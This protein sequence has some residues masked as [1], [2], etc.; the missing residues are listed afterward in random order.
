MAR[1]GARGLPGGT[2]QALLASREAR[3]QARLGRRGRCEN[4]LE[5]ARSAFAGRR[6]DDDPDWVYWVSSAVLAADAGRAHLD[7]GLPREA[8]ADLSTGL[9][10][11]GSAQ[12]RNRALHLTSLAQ[13]HLLAGEVEEAATATDAALALAR[14]N[15]SRRI[16][17]RLQ[18][19]LSSFAAVPA[20][21]AQ[22]TAE[23]V[24]T[25]LAA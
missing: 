24:R 3:V 14:A 22:Q 10:M 4:A 8:A 2:F 9:V 6:E 11:F 20:P 17:E 18:G 1:R 5:D 23:R 21:V 16:T 15:Q 13:A 7:L 12:P 25:A 19:L